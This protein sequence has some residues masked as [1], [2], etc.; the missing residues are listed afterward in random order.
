MEAFLDFIAKYYIIFTIITG[1]LLLSLIGNL[2]EKNS[3]RDVKIK[4]KKSN[5]KIK[6]TDNVNLNT[7]SEVTNNEDT[8]QEQTPQL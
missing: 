2:V 8:T 3:S 7:K 1:V 5:K 4:N 6:K